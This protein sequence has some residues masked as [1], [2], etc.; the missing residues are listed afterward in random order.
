M[1]TFCNLLPVVWQCTTKQIGKKQTISLICIVDLLQCVSYRVP[2]NMSEA[3]EVAN[4]LVKLD[5]ADW[6]SLRELYIRNWPVHFIGYLTVDT[7]IRWTKKQPDIQDVCIYSLNGDWSDGTFICTVSK[8]TILIK[9]A[10]ANQICSL[11]RIFHT[12]HRNQLFI[13]TLNP[14]ID[15]LCALVSLVD[16]S[17]TPLCSTILNKHRAAIDKTV[18]DNRLGTFYDTLT[19]VYYMPSKEAANLIIK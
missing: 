5:R 3:I 16:W 13:N 12:Q 1:P 19:N 15:R 4:Q 6:P 8:Y 11:Y 9:C 17:V 7:F 2:L 10:F 14:S 18:A